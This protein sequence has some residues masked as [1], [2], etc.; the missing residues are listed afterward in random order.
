MLNLEFVRLFEENQRVNIASMFTEENRSE[1]S[2]TVFLT[3]FTH[4]IDQLSRLFVI[5]EGFQGTTM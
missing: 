4:G 1:R 2:A 3:L 5:L